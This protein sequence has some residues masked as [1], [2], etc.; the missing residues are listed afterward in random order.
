MN[1]TV[2]NIHIDGLKADPQI[3]AQAVSK[4]LNRLQYSREDNPLPLLTASGRVLL[5]IMNQPGITLREAANTL[6]VTEANVQRIVADL[7][8][9]DIV[10]RKGEGRQYHYQVNP[11]AFFS[12]PDI[13]NMITAI[14]RQLET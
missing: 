10:T 3:I 5:L 8:M 11:D 2:I 12:H 14:S 13:R 6:S 9:K 4:A 7:F 1:E